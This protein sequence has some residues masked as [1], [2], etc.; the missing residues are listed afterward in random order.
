VKN[1]TRAFIK[2]AITI[3]LIA[4]LIGLV[5]G[6]ALANLDQDGRFTSWRLINSFVKFRHISNATTGSIQAE[7]TDNKIY[8][9][10]NATSTEDCGGWSEKT[11]PMNTLLNEKITIEKGTCV[12]EGNKYPKNPAGKV[13]ECVRTTGDT[14]DGIYVITYYA[15]LDDGSIWIWKYDNFR[16][17]IRFPIVATFYGLLMGIFLSIFF[18]FLEKRNNRTQI[19]IVSEK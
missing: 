16:A 6:I 11:C 7:S 15:L 1:K 17:L 14:G 18:Y 9:H 5:I 2:R 4:T 8:S 19:T 12:I 13:V 10:T 3:T